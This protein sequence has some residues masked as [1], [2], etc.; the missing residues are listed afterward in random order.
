MAGTIQSED[1]M[2]AVKSSFGQEKSYAYDAAG[3]ITSEVDALG[4][5]TYYTYSL[6]GKLI[7][8]VDAAGNR[9]EY[10]YD[11]MG[12]LITIC[13]HQ[14]SNTLLKEDEQIFI[15]SLQD[16]KLVHVTQYKRNLFG[17]IETITD[18]LGL[19]ELYS[20]DLAGQMVSKKDKEN[21]ITQYAYNPVGDIESITYADGRSVTYTYNS[22][23]QLIEIQD[24]L[25]TIRIE[26]DDMGRAKKVT[27]HRDR[28]IAYQWGRMGEREAIIYPVKCS[29]SI[30]FK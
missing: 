10:A 17:K 15:S 4:H 16:E 26:P 28:E 13:Q 14:G 6:G 7:S 5:K 1:R 11:A 19:Q 29:L 20:Y 9:T 25:G 30:Y 2:T 22:L 8:V 24:W 12:D 18:P 27:D 23:R 21:Y 3:N